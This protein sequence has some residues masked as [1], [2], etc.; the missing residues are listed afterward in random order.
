MQVAARPI[1][2]T[3]TSPQAGSASGMAS[4]AHEAVP[5]AY[6]DERDVG[7]LLG[8]VAATAV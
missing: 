6:F 4:V 3:G 1:D 7:D 5:F 2:T 8:L